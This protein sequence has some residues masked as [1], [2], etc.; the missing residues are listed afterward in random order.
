[1]LNLELSALE[2]DKRGKVVSSP[3]VT[4][5]NQQKAIIEQ[6]KILYLAVFIIKMPEAKQV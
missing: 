2:S 3:R 4:T 1:M 6:A 5:A